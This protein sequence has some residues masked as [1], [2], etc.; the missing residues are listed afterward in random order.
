MEKLETIFY[1]TIIG[2]IVVFGAGMYMTG[3]AIYS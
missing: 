2:I 1:T 3:S